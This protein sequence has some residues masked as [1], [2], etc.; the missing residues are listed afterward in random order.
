MDVLKRKGSFKGINKCK[1]TQ[2]FF[3]LFKIVDTGSTGTELQ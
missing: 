1:R 2:N 3:N